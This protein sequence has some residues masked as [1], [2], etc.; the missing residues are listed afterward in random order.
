M[1]ETNAFDKQDVRLVRAWGSSKSKN[2]TCGNL[3]PKAERLTNDE[4]KY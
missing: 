1:P 2:V 4:S 3:I